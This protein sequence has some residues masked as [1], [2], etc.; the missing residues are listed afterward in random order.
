M[1]HYFYTKFSIRG[2]PVFIP[3]TLLI[4]FLEDKEL[5]F[6]LYVYNIVYISELNELN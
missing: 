4:L 5:L 6:I 2:P 3:Y 1:V